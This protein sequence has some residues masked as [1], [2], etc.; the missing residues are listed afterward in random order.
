[1]KMFLL[2]FTFSVVWPRP[3]PRPTFPLWYFPTPGHWGPMPPAAP[4]TYWS[5]TPDPLLLRTTPW[6]KDDR[7]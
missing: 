7:D 3:A 1:M 6:P 2:I 5:P 4:G